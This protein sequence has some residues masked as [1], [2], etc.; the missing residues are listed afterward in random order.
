LEQVFELL[1]A[2]G[3][4]PAKVSKREG[5]SPQAI[6]EMLCQAHQ[7]VPLQVSRLPALS[8]EAGKEV[9]DEATLTTLRS[10]QTL[11]QVEPGT[12]WQGLALDLLMGNLDQPLWGWADPKAIHVLNYWKLLDP[13]VVFVLVYDAPQSVL[14]A[15]LMES[16]SEDFHGERAQQ[17]VA[18][19]L[20]QW[21][22]YNQTLLEFFYNNQSRCLLIQADHVLGAQPDMLQKVRTQL[23]API[24]MTEL[25]L[26]GL[27]SA[28]S[29]PARAN[30]GGEAPAEPYALLAR[31]IAK[32]L[33]PGDHPSRLLFSELQAAGSLSVRRDQAQRN[34]QLAL[35]ALA[36]L[37]IAQQEQASR[38]GDLEQEG[39]RAREELE[40]A[41]LQANELSRDRSRLE[42][43]L[44]S[45]Q[46]KITQLESAPAANQKELEEENELLLAQLHQVQEELERYYLENL[47]LKQSGGKTG[48]GPS[49]PLYGAAE[50]I[51]NQL[52]YRLGRSMID[53][54]T[55]FKGWLSMPF[56]ALRIRS[57]FRAERRSNAG[58]SLPPISSYA[59]AYDAERVKQHHSYRIGQHMVRC[60]MTPWGLLRMLFLVR[61]EVRLY[62]AEQGRRR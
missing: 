36:T 24:E 27:D 2:H 52:S 18:G 19:L 40:S 21:S 33:I 4:A 57:A 12:V 50:R 45:L 14:A 10:R 3:L 20:E 30:Q 35:R 47:E 25:E 39:A 42:T 9:W 44:K 58:K 59:D 37:R 5:L 38:L 54:S 60:G 13:T 28:E 31:Q 29:Q 49:Q 11:A 7:V 34:T 17:R 23:E 8:H 46:D 43:S 26:P 16:D 6:G 56:V 1:C 48:Q 51:K 62:L 15:A 32:E 41:R 61:Q 55:S 53:R 22:A